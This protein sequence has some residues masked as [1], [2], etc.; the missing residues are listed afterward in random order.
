MK[1][2]EMQQLCD[3]LFATMA[4]ILDIRQAPDCPAITAKAVRV[5]LTEALA[6]T[7]GTPNVMIVWGDGEGLKVNVGRMKG[8]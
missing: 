1:T 2:K 3:R 5:A 7:V 6:E 8:G 4:A